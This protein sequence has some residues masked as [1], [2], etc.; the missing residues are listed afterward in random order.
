M[1]AIMRNDIKETADLASDAPRPVD[2]GT[3]ERLI[4]Y[5]DIAPLVH[6]RIKDTGIRLPSGLRDRLEK[7]YYLAIAKGQSLWAEFLRISKAFRDRNAA[8]VPIKGTSFLAD[9][10]ASNPC[11]PMA[12]IDILVEERSLDMARALLTEAGY[13]EE[14]FGLD[15]AYW[16]LN[17]CHITFVKERIYVE[18]HFGL[19]FKRGN[20]NI[21]PRLW[22]RVR[23][24]S[25]DGHGVSF[26]SYEDALF[27]LA[28]HERRFGRTL[29]L[30]NILDV[31]LILKNKGDA[32][33]WDYIVDEA[34]AGKM[35]SAVFFI[36]S[37]AKIFFKSDIP[38]GVPAGLG[39]PYYKRKAIENMIRRNALSARIAARNKSLYTMKHFLLFDSLWEPASYIYHI[40]EEQFAKFYGL[41][42]YD[43]KTRLLYRLRGLSMPYLWARER[44]SRGAKR[45]RAAPG[46][47]A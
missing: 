7:S 32:L 31:S 3:I 17:Q 10:Y 4:A 37:A 44:L 18:V 2:W 22:E 42:P 27:S 30:K 5:H 16:R 21:L 1:A 45:R 12:D 14:S 8:M 25:V 28:L 6:L 46:K 23:E 20:R 19:D 13:R 40:P 26:L 15:E 38:Q 11:R 47:D 24:R 39:V 36:L 29:G 35:S 9:I 43:A 33:D 34:R 41:E